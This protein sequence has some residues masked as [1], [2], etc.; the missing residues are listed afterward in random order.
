M[1]TKGCRQSHDSMTEAARL[2]AEGEEEEKKKEELTF[3][4]RKTVLAVMAKVRM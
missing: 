3:S 4:E 2:A 1:V